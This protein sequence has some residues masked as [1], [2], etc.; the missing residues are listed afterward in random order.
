MLDFSGTALAPIE[1]HAALHPLKTERADLIVPPGGT[2]DDIF[3]LVQPDPVLRRFAH[4]YI[5]PNYI[6]PEYWSVVRPKPGTMVCIRPFVAPRGGANGKDIMRSVLLI[7]VSAAALAFGGPLAGAIGLTGAL[8]AA[9]GQAVIGIGGMLL[10]NA[11]IPPRSTAT[12]RNGAEDSPLNF[13]E[14]ARN[15]ADPFGPVPDLFGKMRVI[16]KLAAAPYTEIVGDDQYLN[17]LFHWGIGPVSFDANEF[18]IGENLLT[19]YDEYRVQHREGY[20]GDAAITLFPNVVT[21]DSF[22]IILLE[23]DGY[24]IRTS[25]ADADRIGIDI[26]FAEGL[27][28]V[29]DEGRRTNRSVTVQVQYSVA[30]A[31]SWQNIPVANLSRTFPLDWTNSNGTTFN[32]IT[33]TSRKTTAIREGFTFDPPTRDQFDI[34]I[35]RVTADSSS[36]QIRDVISWAA[37]RT[38]TNENPVQSPVPVALTALRIK[39]TDQ[40][41]GVIDEFNGLPTR[42]CLDWNGASWV[43]AATQNPASLFRYALQSN[44]L[45]EPVADADIDLVQLQHWHEYCDDNGFT[46]NE[47]RDFFAPHSDVL[48]D[49]AAAGR[50]S[51]QMIDGKYSV[52]IDEPKTPVQMVTSRNAWGFEANK[53]FVDKPHAI[54]IQFKNEEKDYRTDELRVYLDGYTEAT[55]T[56]FE[57]A[58]Y[59]GITNPDHLA[60]AA[61]FDAAVAIHRPEQFTFNQDMERLVYRRGDVIVLNYDVILV[62]NGS[63]RIRSL[64]MTGP[65]VS[66]VVVDTPLVFDT[67]VTYGLAIRTVDDAAIVRQIVD[68]GVDGEQTTLTFTNVIPAAAGLVGGELFSFGPLGLETDEALIIDIDPAGDLYDARVTAVPYREIVYTIDSGPIPPFDSRITP[69]TAVPDV[70]VKGVRSDETV[71]TVG[72]GEA[73]SVHIGVKVEPIEDDGSLDV[74]IR[75]STT[76]EA[77]KKAQVDQYVAN[78]VFIGDV[79]TGE[80]FDIRLRWN[81]PG[82]VPGDWTYV[83]NHLVVGKST[84]PEPLTN[85]TVSAFGGQAFIRWDKPTALDVVFGGTVSFRHTEELPAEWGNSLSIGNV[86]QADAGIATL[87]L[88]AGTYL[89]QV[90]DSSGLSS[91]TSTVETKQASVLEFTLEFTVAEAPLFAGTKT[92]VIADSINSETML[93]LD[94]VGLWDDIS[95]LDADVVRVDA[96]GGVSTVS[97]EYVF[98]NKFDFG[99]VRLMRLTTQLT[100]FNAAVFDLIDDWG[101]DIDDR[102]NF[103]GTE[104]AVCDCIIYVSLTDDDPASGGATWGAYERL[105][106]AEVDTRGCRFKAVLSS[107]SADYNIYVSQLSIVAE[108]VV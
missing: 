41:N 12:A 81:L 60:K 82:R 57:T 103:D 30:G 100:T 55:A 49:V 42:V 52:V 20:A 23:P 85:M 16:P 73:L 79:R 34:R 21:Q 31:A 64:V 4:I 99:S 44:A 87:P 56:K 25:A 83:Y 11:L 93:F 43:L 2:L 80:Y 15:V 67:S 46:Y 8:G 102:D 39:A 22:S 32:Q 45:Q 91:T 66:G 75:P 51:P 108:A 76:G 9:V 86:A 104:T 53:A 26:I 35:K 5:G 1:V 59:P 54:R 37:L 77:F 92:G 69:I 72:P 84:A 48:A 33:F 10:I 38:Y 88:K 24:T 18:K 105:D 68:P 71:L 101:G 62:G 65:D 13:I 3:A 95:N 7:A 36:D 106:S 107:T 40:L 98:A 89:A 27:V 90:T 96:Y 19:Q 50:A 70:E 14:N 29:D 6:D 17:M 28:K 94:A 97:G 58:S 63:G 61:R 47:W 74:Q 78:E